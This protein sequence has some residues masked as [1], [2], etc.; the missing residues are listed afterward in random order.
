MQGEEITK[1]SFSKILPFFIVF[2][3]KT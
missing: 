3:R 1:S 2:Q